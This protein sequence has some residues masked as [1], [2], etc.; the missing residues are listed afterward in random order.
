M[1]GVALIVRGWLLTQFPFV[2]RGFA[3]MRNAMRDISTGIMIVQTVVIIPVFLL[4]VMKMIQVVM[5]MMI[6]VMDI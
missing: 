6:T 1:V 3:L 4:R 5:V 2:I